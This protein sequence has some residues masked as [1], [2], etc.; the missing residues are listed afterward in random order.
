VL[1]HEPLA[2]QP[3]RE[4]AFCDAAAYNKDLN[5]LHIIWEEYPIPQGYSRGAGDTPLRLVGLTLTKTGKI[6][7]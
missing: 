6:P 4:M 7:V 2:T 3:S 5:R 1:F